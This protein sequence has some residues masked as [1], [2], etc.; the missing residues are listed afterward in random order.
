MEDQ[1]KIDVW[2]STEMWLKKKNIYSFKEIN[3]DD[4]FDLFFH[5]FSFNYLLCEITIIGFFTEGFHS[6]SQMIS[7]SV[8]FPS[9][10]VQLMH[11]FPLKIKKT[12]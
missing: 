2:F 4:F 6:F 7:F 8:H 9:F 11:D 12:L 1:R 5:L 10:R 3:F